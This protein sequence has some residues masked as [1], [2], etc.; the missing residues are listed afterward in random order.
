MIKLEKSSF[1]LVFII[2]LDIRMNF[3]L[4]Y[5]IAATSHY[6]GRRIALRKDIFKDRLKLINL[7]QGASEDEVARVHY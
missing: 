7:A 3:R 2:L 5:H 1:L 6:F 4:S